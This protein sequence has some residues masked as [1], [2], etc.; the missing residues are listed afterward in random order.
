[1]VVVVGS[2]VVWMMLGVG[3]TFGILD[4]PGGVNGLLVCPLR[5]SCRF[6]QLRRSRYRSRQYFRCK[7]LYLLF[8]HRI[9]VRYFSRQNYL[10]KSLRF[11]PTA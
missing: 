11:P 2:R 4:V 8:V 6:V 10:C 9:D 3:L 5:C 1:M 7:L